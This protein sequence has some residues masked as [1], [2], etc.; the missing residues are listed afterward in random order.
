MRF[1]TGAVALLLIGLGLWA[2]VAPDTFYSSIATYPPYSPHLV[3]DVG[4]F[5]IGLGACL[6]LALLVRDALLAGLGVTPPAPSRTSARTLPTGRQAAMPAIRY[7]SGS[8]Q[9]C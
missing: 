7:W 2:M 9:W 8:S 3:H 4:A 5:Q 6:A 1:V